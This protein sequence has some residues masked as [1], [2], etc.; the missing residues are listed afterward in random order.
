MTKIV[1][2]K[3][4]KEKNNNKNFATT[5]WESTKSECKKIVSKNVSKKRDITKLRD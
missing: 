3:K 2:E 5:K 4:C 1:K